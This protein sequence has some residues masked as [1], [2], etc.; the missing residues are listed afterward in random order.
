M[1]PGA[2]CGRAARRISAPERR[3]R[4]ESGERAAYRVPSLLCESIGPVVM[5]AGVVRSGPLLRFYP[6]PPEQHPPK[7]PGNPAVAG[8]GVEYRGGDAWSEGKNTTHRAENRGAAPIV[9]ALADVVKPSVTVVDALRAWPQPAPTRLS[10]DAS[11][12]R[13]VHLAALLHLHHVTGAPR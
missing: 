4:S 1:A 10:Q 3:R 7:Y 11:R 5:L 8:E 12:E 9:I 2:L 6:L 13:G